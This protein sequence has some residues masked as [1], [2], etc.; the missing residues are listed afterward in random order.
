LPRYRASEAFKL[1]VFE[2]YDGGVTQRKLARGHGIGTATIER[3]Y[4]RQISLRYSET[5]TKNYPL[6]L[7][8]D[9]H[10]IS[11]KAGFAITFVVNRH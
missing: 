10:F 6:V 9:E 5:R 3:W 4:Q 7:G 8:I 11:R 1:E 2:T